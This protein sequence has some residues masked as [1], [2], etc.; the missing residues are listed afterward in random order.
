MCLIHES[1]ISGEVNN[2]LKQQ[3]RIL[4]ANRPR[5]LREIF[6][7][8]FQRYPDVEIVGEIG[9]SDDISGQ[10]KASQADWVLVPLRTD[11]KFPDFVKL[12][13]QDYPG[14]GILAISAD[15]SQARVRCGDDS[16]DGVEDLSLKELMDMIR[17][18]IDRHP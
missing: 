15:G 9:N 6:K 2:N 17:S 8:A 14:I 18:D 16:R 1:E 3:H 11:G 13:I 4:L 7:Y 5:L 10:I 12:I